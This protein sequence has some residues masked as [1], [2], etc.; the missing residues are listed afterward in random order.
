MYI[1]KYIYV[2][3]SRVFS[4]SSFKNQRLPLVPLGCQLLVLAA[5]GFFG[6]GVGKFRRS[7]VKKLGMIVIAPIDGIFSNVHK[8]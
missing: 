1:Y 3:H 2:V 7:E 6:L 4:S 5:P 8:S